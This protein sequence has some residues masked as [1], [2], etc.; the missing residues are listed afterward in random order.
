M[1]LEGTAVERSIEDSAID[2]TKR[3]GT[4]EQQAQELLAQHSHFR[5]RAGEFEFEYQR[6]VLVVRGR[7]P[8]FYLKQVLQTVLKDLDGVTWIDNRV[9]VVCSEGV[10]SVRWHSRRPAD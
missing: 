5:Q 2:P 4:I 9:D 6:D 3:T 1:L 8:T 7:V 10:S